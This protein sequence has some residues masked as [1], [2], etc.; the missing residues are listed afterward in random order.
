MHAS[1]DNLAILMVEMHR[2]FRRQICDDML[3]GSGPNMLQFHALIGIRERDEGMTM[4]DF[5]THMRI[6]RPSATSFAERLVKM[7]W[8]KRATD[9]K[10]RR[11]VRLRLTPQAERLMEKTMESRR[12]TLTNLLATLTEKD[13][14]DFLRILHTLVDA[15]RSTLPSSAS[16]PQS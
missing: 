13:K 8:V 12:Q 14:D 10:N 7:G 15:M 11:V 16:T 5:A 9:P 3:G 2:L 4:H 1:T 6:T